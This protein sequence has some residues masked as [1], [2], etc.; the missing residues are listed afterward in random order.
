MMYSFYDWM[1]SLHLSL[2]STF[3]MDKMTFQI[4]HNCE[5]ECNTGNRILSL[6]KGNIKIDLFELANMLHSNVRCEVVHTHNCMIIKFLNFL[7]SIDF[8]EFIRIMHIRLEYQIENITDK[9]AIG[10]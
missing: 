8:Q 10:M 1:I 7:T 6:K 9:N 3:V 4:A 5:I 2:I